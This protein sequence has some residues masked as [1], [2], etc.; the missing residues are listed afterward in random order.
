[1][2]ATP[3]TEALEARFRRI[4][5]LS[6]IA[7]VLIWDQSVLMPSGGCEARAEQ[8]ANLSVLR[9]E[10]LTAP[11]VAEQLATAEEEMLEGWRAA[12]LLEMRRL[13][14]HEIALS[15]KLVDALSRA[16][17]RCEILWREARAEANFSIVLKALAE[18]IALIQE[19]ATA[20]AEIMKISPYE[21]LLRRYEPACSI[22]SIEK[23]F[24]ELEDQLPSLL[25]SVLEY[26]ATR[27]DPVQPQGPFPI[28]I[29]RALSRM[30]MQAIG[31]NFNYGRLDEALHPFCGGVPDDVRITTRYEDSSFISAIMGIIH[32][33]GHALYE[34]GLPLAWR[35][36]PVGSA[37]GMIM[38]ESQSLL[39]EMQACRSEAFLDLLS[40]WACSA[41]SI[42]LE[43]KN[44][45]RICTKVKRG[46]IR[47]EADEITYPLHVIVRTRLERAMLSGDLQVAY[48]PSTWNAEMNELIGV[49]PPND[50]MGCLQDIHWYDGA[51]GYF[52][53][54]T[55]GAIT[56]AQIFQA[57]VRDERCIPEAIGRGDFKPLV[58]WLARNIHDL[59]SFKSTE[60][61]IN[62]ATGANLSTVPFLSHIKNRYLDE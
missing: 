33:T 38:H 21:A 46:C 10:L 24:G 7:S 15:S 18:L 60:E 57:A 31:F 30:V 52:P 49:T 47:V 61:I 22:N 42:S 11:D 6:G 14:F 3:A 25:N 36:Q 50:A 51:F 13:Y 32:E 58:E 62:M 28:A 16:S 34:R 43:P 45:F 12:N 20:K 56:A 1:M 48:L 39:M 5:A 41:F 40:D 55:L 23:L 8:L 19:E 54:Y 26:Q 2:T 17:L 59:A 37:R 35:T 4:S 53:M 27:S 29:Q 44:L 9:H